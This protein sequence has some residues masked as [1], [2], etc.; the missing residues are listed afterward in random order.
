MT[1]FN[2]A[3]TVLLIGLTACPGAGGTPNPDL[4]LSS[5]SLNVPKGGSGSVSI[6]LNRANLSG[7]VAITLAGLPVGV[8]ALTP[9]IPA[10]SSTGTLTIVASAAATVGGPVTVTVR[11][12][13]GS[14]IDSAPLALT[15]TAGSSAPPPPSPPSPPSP[16][17]PAL[18]LNG[19]WSDNGRQVRITHSGASV[20]ALYLLPYICE[21][22]DGSGGSEQTDF[23]FQAA[24]TDH[25]L[26]GQTTICSYGQGNPQGVGLKL[27]QM[28][29]TVAQDAKSI[30]G[31]WHN[32]F[33]NTDQAINLTRISASSAFRSGHSNARD[34]HDNREGR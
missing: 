4:V 30:S 24:L 3:V 25:R 13:S 15:I 9:T 6:T 12:S 1:R 7:V 28:Q 10:S 33:T 23:D 16:P 19:L 11:G 14:L 34:A 31:T 5:P 8:S 18:D 17:L 22:R 20:E 32:T 29:L 27:A 2:L 21:F 26:T